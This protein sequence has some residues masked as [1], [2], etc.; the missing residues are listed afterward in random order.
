MKGG[1]HGGGLA[2]VAPMEDINLHFNG[3]LHAVT[4]ANNLL[5]S[6]VDNHLYWDNPLGIDPLRITW[7]RVLDINDRA[8]RS[9]DIGMRGKVKRQS[10]FDIT[11]ASEI[12]AILCLAEN[13]QDLQNRLS[14]IVIGHLGDGSVVTAGD[15][16]AD[17]ALTVLLS[18]ALNPN[19]V[20][21]LEH[22][23]VF[24]HGGPFANIAHGCSSIV[25]TRVALNLC[26]VVVT[27][28]GFGADLGA[29]KFFN[30]KCRQAALNAEAAVVVCTVR[31]LKM[32]GGV[33]RD[34]LTESN[35]HAVHEGSVNLRRHIEN[36][37]QFGLLPVVALNRFSSDTDD[38]IEAVKSIGQKYGVR[39]YVVT[40]WQDGGTGTEELAEAVMDSLAGEN[41]G[42]TCLYSEDLSLRD[43]IQTVA[44]HIYRA[45]R[46]TYDPKATDKLAEIE[47]LGYGKLPVCIAKTQYSFSADPNE[48]GAPERHTLPVRE[49]SLSAGAGFVVVICG[50]IM[51]MPGLPRRPA[52]LDFGFDDQGRIVGL[53]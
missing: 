45:G 42:S 12:M 30:I 39:V 10:G 15:L 34:Q 8:L 47:K 50:D 40:H 4:V 29:E 5:A 9:I 33:S 17:G 21:T 6:L 31:S 26:E 28:A 46:V 27:E 19:V 53:R 2:Q 38:E 14:G 13:R 20:Q 41:D 44:T 36:I 49:V 16:N 23:P 35:V 48:L 52:A 25:A 3:D 11:A 51:T 18:D 37:K 32:H 7:R 24:V 1:A 43:K 22:N